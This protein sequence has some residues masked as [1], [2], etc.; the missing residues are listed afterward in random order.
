MTIT[1]MDLAK[2][3]RKV[4]FWYKG[5]HYAK[6]VHGGQRF[7]TEVEAKW[8]A[9]LAEGEHFPHRSR[10]MFEEVADQF[11]REYAVHL[12]SADKLKIYLAEAKR[13]FAG[14][15]AAEINPDHVKAF[16]TM[17][18]AR[19]TPPSVN[20]YHKGLR[21]ALYWAI[22]R[23]WMKGP[24][25]ASGHKVKLANE[26][27]YWRS[28][29]LS[30]EELQRLLDNADAGLSDII[31]CA[32]MLGLRLGEVGRLRKRDVNLD[33]CIVFIRAKKTDDGTWLPF[34][35]SLFP[36]LDR[37]V[38]RSRGAD[39]VLHDMTNYDK[40]W[41]EARLKAGLKDIK[42]T[43]L[44]HTTASHVLQNNSG[45]LKVVQEVLRHSDYRMT[46]RY[47]HLAPSQVRTAILTLDETFKNLRTGPRGE[48]AAPASVSLE[49]MKTAT[50]ALVSSGNQEHS[51]A[52][53]A[54]PT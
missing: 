41:L 19:M 25:P 22:E 20:H 16:R 6:V 3:K 34:P 51:Q 44:R 17:L 39:E 5:V 1:V 49:V 9:E 18:S 35:N 7:A 8:R 32:T 21:R 28:R 50:V 33:K 47:A 38:K 26:R 15:R 40:R 24:N 12:A 31:L 46:E 36:T 53:T 52:T 43:D 2:G 10:L 37:L 11:M 29:Y 4:S 13:F 45:N 30:E 54:L 42:F 14:K 23:G 27:P 48:L